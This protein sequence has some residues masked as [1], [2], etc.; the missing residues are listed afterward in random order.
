MKNN[1]TKRIWLA[2]RITLVNKTGSL[3][4]ESVYILYD[5]QA[6]LITGFRYSP[7]LS[8]PALTL[9]DLVREASNDYPVPDIV[10]TD[11]ICPCKAELFCPTAHPI[12]FED[13]AGTIKYK[14]I[15]EKLVQSL[16]RYLSYSRISDST[17]SSDGIVSAMEAVVGDYNSGMLRSLF[18][19]SDKGEIHATA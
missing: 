10:K 4:G 6:D 19:P 12:S 15:L 17:I 8:K 9:I 11:L 3:S 16:R 13:H 18:R 14:I 5:P 2:D 1:V 7:D